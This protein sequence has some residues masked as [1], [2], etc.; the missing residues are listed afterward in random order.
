MRDMLGVLGGM[1]P[2]SS[3][4]FYKL[5]TERTAANRDQEHV[6][7]LLLSDTEV[8][9]RTDAILKDR[10]GPVLE[11][12]R[13]D[14]RLLEES[15]CRGIAAACNTAHYFLDLMEGEIRV[16]VLHMV[17]L[18]A[19]EAARRC[20][21]G[22]VA[23][24]ATEGTL[25]AGLYQRALRQ[26]GLTC[27]IPGRQAQTVVNDAIFRQIKRGLR[28]D[29]DAW[30]RLETTLRGAGC[31]LIL[32]GCTELSC[33]KD[34]EH[35]EDWYLDP[36]EVLAEASIVFMGRPLRPRTGGPAPENR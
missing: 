10:P 23:I 26:R 30:G 22:Q 13:A 32:L 1:G 35:L 7:L 5:V 19:E 6:P 11:R 27:Y 15:G 34:Q 36:L 17:H 3:Q 8:P 29:M 31:G 24:L 14:V 20:P 4:L 33:I 28:A 21:G 2:L 16:P 9:D 25:R 12:L 18:A